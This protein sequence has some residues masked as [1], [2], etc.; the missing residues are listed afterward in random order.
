MNTVVCFKFIFVQALYGIWRDVKLLRFLGNLHV[1][2]LNFTNVKR[3]L[4]SLRRP[5]ISI[6]LV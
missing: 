4:G 5:F 6:V 1:T 2:I 3:S